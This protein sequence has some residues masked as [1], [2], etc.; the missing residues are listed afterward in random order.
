M[1]AMM[2]LIQLITANMELPPFLTDPFRGVRPL[3]LDRHGDE[4]ARGEMLR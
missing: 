4:L 1:R 2:R 3:V